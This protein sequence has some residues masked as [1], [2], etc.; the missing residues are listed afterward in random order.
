MRSMNYLGR[1]KVISR[2]RW[3]GQ[4]QGR[5]FNNGR[6]GVGLGGGRDLKME[7]HWP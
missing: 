4:S 7:H 1:S 3:E 6:W 5:T 2:G